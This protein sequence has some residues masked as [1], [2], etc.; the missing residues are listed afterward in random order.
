MKSLFP[1]YTDDISKFKWEEIQI[2]FSWAQQMNDVPQD[3]IF[4]F[5]GNVGIHTRMVLEALLTLPEFHNQTEENKFV[6]FMACLFHDIEKRSTTKE[7]NGRI[8]SPGHAKKGE[9]TTR[10]ILYR[11]FSI[12]FVMREKIAKL[13]RH[14]GLPLWV[15]EKPNPQQVIIEASLVS[16]TELLSI[17]AK[18][19]V[20]GRICNDAPELFYK[21][22]LFKELAMENNCFGIK[23]NFPNELA[24]FEYFKKNE[25]YSEYTPYDDTKFEAIILSGIPGSGKDYFIKKSLGDYPVV[26]LDKLRLKHKKDAKKGSGFVVQLAKEQAREYMRKKQ[27]FIWNA[28]NITKLIR[29]QLIEMC[30]EYGGKVKLVY[31]EVPYK[32]VLHQNNNRQY[33]I[34][35]DVLERFIDKLEMPST[36]E[37]HEVSYFING[38]YVTF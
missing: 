33:P 9:Q 14:H 1:F 10:Q 34:P 4:H 31:I 32:T 2:N 13:V 11:D 16:D 8:V 37:A 15:F 36:I 7:E 19:D 17:I 25:I 29:S 23:K 38:E 27:S 35:N 24:K 3:S 18:V 21:I 5:E 26:S 28:T 6:L 20:L 30:S 12:P 22:E